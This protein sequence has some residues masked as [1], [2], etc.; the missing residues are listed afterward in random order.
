M[1]LKSGD[2]VRTKAGEV[3]HVVHVARLT[4]FVQIEAPRK[5]EGPK[6]LLVS[7]LTKIDPPSGRATFFPSTK[8]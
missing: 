2:W 7:T 8:S 6:A 1:E 5:G 4:A 3:G